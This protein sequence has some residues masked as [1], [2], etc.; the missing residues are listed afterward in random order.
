MHRH[1][2][3]HCRCVLSLRLFTRLD[4]IDDHGG[5]TAGFDLDVS[6]SALAILLNRAAIA[7]N[8]DPLAVPGERV[9]YT[10]EGRGEVW[11]KPLVGKSFA[12]VLWNRNNTYSHYNPISRVDLIF[13]GACLVHAFTPTHNVL[14]PWIHRQSSASRVTQRCRICG[15]ASRWAS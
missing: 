15:Q 9:R 1:D 10:R 6:A 4:R 11:A 2:A 3:P 8:Q 14:M 5:D 7:V 12:A 13:A